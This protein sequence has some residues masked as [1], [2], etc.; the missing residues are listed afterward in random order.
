MGRGASLRSFYSVLP[1]IHDPFEVTLGN[2]KLIAA[3]IQGLKDDTVVD[4]KLALNK[5]I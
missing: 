3:E 2:L 5:K 4:P 1:F